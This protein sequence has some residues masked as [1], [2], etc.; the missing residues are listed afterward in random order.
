[1]IPGNTFPV[2]EHAQAEKSF[3]GKAIVPGYQSHFVATAIS[4][5]PVKKPEKHCFSELVIGQETQILPVFILRVDL[6]N[7]MELVK[8]YQRDLPSSTQ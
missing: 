5:F 7:A 8:R 4:G 6:S 2:I 1:V 3:A